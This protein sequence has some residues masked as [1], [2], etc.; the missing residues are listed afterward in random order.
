MMFRCRER[1]IRFALKMP[2]KNARSVTHHPQGR[3]RA[4][5]HREAEYEQQC[6]TYWRRLLLCIKAKLE[7]VETGIETFEEAFLAQIV[8]PDQSTVGQWSKGAIAAAYAN[9]Q[10]PGQLLAL[11]PNRD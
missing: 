4:S 11:G 7:S 5:R 8:L 9:N 6:R 1:I 2:D 3:I 10:M